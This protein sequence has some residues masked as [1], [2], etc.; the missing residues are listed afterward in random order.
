MSGSVLVRDGMPSGGVRDGNNNLV[1]GANAMR[2]AD[3]IPMHLAKVKAKGKGT[4]TELKVVSMTGLTRIG[5]GG[6]EYRLVYIPYTAGEMLNRRRTRHMTVRPTFGDYAW[7]DRSK[8]KPDS[9]D[10]G[11]L[12]V[13]IPCDRTHHE[14]WVRRDRLQFIHD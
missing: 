1:T 11:R 6:T 12:D 8:L 2:G 7:A 14:Q 5:K 4:Y 13:V 3:V 10:N 9:P